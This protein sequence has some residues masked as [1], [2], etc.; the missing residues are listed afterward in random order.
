M[1]EKRIT[2]REKYEMLLAIDAVKENP[3]LVEFCEKEIEMLNKKNANGSERKPTER[4]VENEALK[5][6]IL[7]YMEVGESYTVSELIKEVPCLNEL[8]VNRVS[9]LMNRMPEDI[10][11]KQKEKRTSYFVKLV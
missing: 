2:K 1:T 6:E 7:N 5:A 10:V 4:Q 3:M 8:S 11:A 9:A